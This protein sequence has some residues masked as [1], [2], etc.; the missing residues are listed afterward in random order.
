[1]VRKGG[2]K[3]DEGPPDGFDPNDPYADPVAL[4]EQREYL[5][6]EKW[7]DIEKAKIIRERL[8]WCYRIEGVNHLQKCRHLVQQY[9]DAT[10]GV[11]WNK[12]ARPIELH[13]PKVSKSTD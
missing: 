12:E 3:F 5:V 10:R 11:G 4:L 2:V 8:Q 1:M 6:R 7:I 9:L 13:G